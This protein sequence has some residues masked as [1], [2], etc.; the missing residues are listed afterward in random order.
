MPNDIII[1][2]TESLNDLKI[3]TQPK[4]AF[5]KVMPMSRPLN[6]LLDCTQNIVSTIIIVF[7]KC[8][9]AIIVK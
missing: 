2:N 8:I 5:E 7:T 9:P 4:I 6:M 1:M 3:S